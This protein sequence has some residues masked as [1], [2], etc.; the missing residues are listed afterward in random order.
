VIAKQFHDIAEVDIQ[1]LVQNQVAESKTIEY[2]RALP[3]GTD[4]DKKEFLA[5][6][7]SFANTSGGDLLYGVEESRGIPTAVV[8]LHVADLD[9]EKRRLDQIVAQGIEPRIRYNICAVQC[10]SGPVLVVRIP[11]SWH[12]PHRVVLQGHDKFYARNSTGKYPLDVYELRDAFKR[13]AGIAERLRAFRVDRIIEVS[14]KRTPVPFVDGPCILLHVLPFESLGDAA[15]FDPILFYREPWRVP[16]LG[17]THHNVRTNFDGVVI[18]NGRP[19]TTY[20]QVFRSGMLETA[21][22][23]LLSHEYEGKRVVAHTSFE[24]GVLNYLPSIFAILNKMG[25]PP[26]VAVALTLLS[27]EGLELWIDQWNSAPGF[28][29]SQNNLILPEQIVDDFS[30]PPGVILKPIFDQIWNTCGFEGTCNLNDEGQWIG[31]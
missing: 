16:L 13:E 30:C 25:V 23:R 5:D 27:V 21:N 22:S 15:L 20:T 28:P 4:S 6:V 24:K 18:H 2:K 11:R 17:G 10:S 26:P 7:S 3:A 29:I 9:L 31:Q 8:G 19:A 14:N 1:S 12:A